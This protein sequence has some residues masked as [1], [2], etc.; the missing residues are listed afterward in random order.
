MWIFECDG[1]VVKIND[2]NLLWI[3]S[4]AVVIFPGILTS[5]VG[6]NGSRNS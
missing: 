1:V 3:K 6:H 5:G 4:D 2:R